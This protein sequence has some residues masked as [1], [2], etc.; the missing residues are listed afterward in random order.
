MWTAPGVCTV[1]TQHEPV[2]SPRLHTQLDPRKA[3]NTED[4]QPLTLLNYILLPHLQK[5]II[6]Q[7]GN[8]CFIMCPSSLGHLVETQV[9]TNLPAFPN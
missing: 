5:D 3:R 9:P 6:K 4:M 7:N 2:A 1:V 8:L